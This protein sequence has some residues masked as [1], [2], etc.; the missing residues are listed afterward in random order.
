MDRLIDFVE[1][2]LTLTGYRTSDIRCWGKPSFGASNGTYW[3]WS[4]NYGDL[5]EPC[6]RVGY[7]FESWNVL[8]PMELEKDDI[9]LF[10]KDSRVFIFRALKRDVCPHCG[11]GIAY[12]VP[13]ERK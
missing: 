13:T 2:Q 8:D 10:M 9:I 3:E 1:L 12:K 4:P 11:S 6:D 5:K 7:V